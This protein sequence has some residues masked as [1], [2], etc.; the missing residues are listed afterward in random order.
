MRSISAEAEL[1]L[2]RFFRRI[3]LLSLTGIRA[4]PYN[5][6]RR[7][8]E[9]QRVATIPLS[10]MGLTG[11]SHS[12]SRSMRN[13]GSAPLLARE[14]GVGMS[15]T[16]QH[17]WGIR[18]PEW[19]S[20]STIAEADFHSC[21]VSPTFLTLFLT[22]QARVGYD[23]TYSFGSDPI[24]ARKLRQPFPRTGQVGREPRP[25]R[26]GAGT[27]STHRKASMG[28]RGRSRVRDECGATPVIYLTPFLVSLLYVVTARQT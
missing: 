3:R 14:S 25:Q 1:H 27:F 5:G 2:E 6:A 26:R 17:S 9:A 23:S 11:R 15:T 24:E 20:S 10:L 13:D 12:R 4:K 28:P 19:K 21:R 8:K 7:A 18:S 22:L 16:S